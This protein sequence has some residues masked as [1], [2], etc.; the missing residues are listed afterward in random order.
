MQNK[1][2]LQS[3]RR[4]KLSCFQNLKEIPFSLS[5]CFLS[6]VCS[7][8]IYA[9]NN[10]FQTETSKTNVIPSAME[11][12]QNVIRVSGKVVDENNVPIIGAAIVEKGT[13]NGTITDA[14]GKFSIDA[15]KGASLVV[16]YIGY[17]EQIV[18]VDSKDNHLTIVLREE[19]ETL[20]EVVVVGYGVQKKV[21]L[22]GSVVSIDSKELLERPVANTLNL[23]Q[24]KVNGLQLVPNNAQ[25]GRDGASLMLRGKGSFSTDASPLVLIDGIIGNM[26]E[27]SPGDIESVS[28]LKDAASAS[29]YG[30]RA[31]N[32][33]ILVTTK[34]GKAGKS[35]VSYNFNYGIQEATRLSDQIWNSATYMEL[36]NQMADRMVA[37][38]KYPQELIDKYKNPN[39]DKNLYPDYNWMEETFH[40]G[41]IMSHNLGVTGGKEKLSYNVSL[42][43]TDQDG[44]LDNHTYSKYTGLLNLTSEVTERVKLGASFNFYYSKLNEPYYTNESLVLFIAQSRPMAGPYLPDGSGKYAYAPLPQNIAG[45]WQNRNPVWAMNE[46]SREEESWR[47]NASLNL[48]VDLVKKDNMKLRWTT[49][50]AFRYTDFFRREHYPANSEGYYFLKESDYLQNGTDEYKYATNFYPE[51]R[52]T[53]RDER[54]VYT[55]VSSILDFDWN[56]SEK[57]SLAALLGIQE[58][59]QE[60]RYLYGY[61]ENYPSDSMQELD[62]GSTS[63]QNLAGGVSE[64]AIRSLFGRVNYSFNDRYLFEANFRYDGTSRIHPD[65]RWGF[66]PSFSGAWRISEEEFIKNKMD[67]VN[68]LKLRVSY[69]VLGNS[70]IGNYPYQEVYT[71]SNYVFD[72][73]LSQGVIQSAL[74]D[75]TLKWETTSVTDLGLDLSVCSGLFS[76][77]IDW[78]NKITDNIL[79]QA[80]IPLSVGMSAPTINYGKMRNRGVEFEIGHQNRIN[81]FSYGASFMASLNKNK[82]LELKAPSY[83]S[84]IYEVGKPYGEHYL[85]IWDGIFQSEDD[86]ANSPKQP[87]GPK[88]GDIKFKDLNNDGVIDGNDRTM[89]EGVYPKMLYSFKVYASYKNWDLSAFFQGV[90]GRKIYTDGFGSVPFAQ[91]ASPTSNYL[92]AWTPENTNTNVPALFDWSYGPMNNMRSTYNLKDASYLRL[93]NLQVGYNFPKSLIKKMGLEFARIYMSGENLF[94]ITDY[95]DYDPE[96]SGDGWHA[97]YPQARTYSLGLNL[98]F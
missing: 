43:Y 22:T 20:D 52:V 6:F 14:D 31:A 98:R 87:Y 19:T 93:K 2:N 56:I 75:K 1:N 11:Y 94:V 62:G 18:L 77:T 83:G 25:P 90:S 73:Q 37:H 72:N 45:D 65:H 49:K 23:L 58:E 95:P 63:G 55:S 15:Q 71:T 40:Q 51:K 4:I 30:S 33:V 91:G 5:F 32:G 70:S 28:V 69:G 10:V 60:T 86:I 35:I 61:R 47:A 38:N 12:N 82:V 13:V 50:A 44:L 74:K 54:S 53:N 89:V 64:Y 80:T 46:T 39:R 27:L 96:R 67:W 41:H 48:D 57:H 29:I 3:L 92:N 26:N 59:G 78:Y 8:T 42:G 68:N 79:S 34:K 36:Y 21:N 17:V 76:I 24:G 88:P 7:S 81:D 97:M 84:Y 66:F 85:Y 16:S 9:D